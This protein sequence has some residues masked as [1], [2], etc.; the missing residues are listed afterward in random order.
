M[1]SQIFNL[2]LNF[3]KEKNLYKINRMNSYQEIISRLKFISKLNKGEKINTKQMY[4]QQEGIATTLSRTFWSQD[5]RINTINFIHETIKFSFELLH[6]YDRSD[7]GPEQ[8]IAKHLVSDLRQVTH[9]LENLK[10]TYILDTKFCCD[11]DTLIE[12]IKAKLVNYDEKYI[13]GENYI[14]EK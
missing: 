7:Y 14:E 12:D 4:V 5:N 13:I 10:Q 11:I 2:G 6:N 8:E 3:V 9:G 1:Y